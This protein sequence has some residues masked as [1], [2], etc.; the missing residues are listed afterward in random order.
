MSPQPFSLTPETLKLLNALEHYGQCFGKPNS[1]VEL[2]ATIGALA[3]VMD[4][5]DRL[6]NQVA[7]YHQQ[8]ENSSEEPFSTL[9]APDSTIQQ[10]KERLDTT[11]AT[12]ILLIRTYLQRI[13]SKLS[14]TEFIDLTQAAVALLG[15]ERPRLRLAEAQRLIYITLKTFDKQLSQPIPTLGE[16]LPKPIDRLLARLVRHQKIIRTQG[17]ETVVMPLAAV[18]QLSPDM[19]RTALANSA[20]TLAPDLDTQDGLNDLAHIVRFKLQVTS[21]RSTKSAKEIAIQLTQAISEF[22]SEDSGDITR[23]A[24]DDDLSVSSLFFTPDNFATTS[25]DVPW[26]KTQ[27][28]G[29]TLKDE[30][31]S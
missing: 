9:A 29:K 4:L 18:Q 3:A 2:Q 7:I 24:W 22:Q 14:A 17:L 30:T 20:V 27:N 6:I 23:P 10:A 15:Q 11:E 19:I 31:N 13:S 26:S 12:L 28:P 21:A 16:R 25:N 1:A 8:V 5:P